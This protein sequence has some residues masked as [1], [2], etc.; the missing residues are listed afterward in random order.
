MQQAT[1]EYSADHYVQRLDLGD[2]PFNVDFHN[3]YFYAHGMR[4]QILDQVLHFGRFSDQAVLLLGSTGVGTSS[5][6]G[7][8]LDQLEPV[9]DFCSID[10]E[11]ISSPEQIL[12][13]LAEQMQLGSG[14]SA[15]SLLA[16]LRQQQGLGEVEPLLIAVD[17]AHFMG[18]EG[19]GLLQYLY[20]HAEG[21]IHLLLVGEYQVEQ[22]VRLV[23]LAPDQYKVLEIEPLTAEETGEYLL[24]L[25]QSVGYGGEQPLNRDQLAVLVERT[26][27]NIAE[28]KR[29]A[30]T[31]LSSDSKAERR[32]VDL[33]LPI[34]HIAAI[35]VLVVV[36]LVSY[37]FQSS[38]ERKDVV[39]TS[40]ESTAVVNRQENTL[41]ADDSS[42]KPEPILLS[43]PSESNPESVTEVEVVAL[44][45]EADRD[46]KEA[47]L[48]IVDRADEVGASEQLAPEEKP[49][50]LQID[51]AEEAETVE[52]Q[53][54]QTQTVQEPIVTSP[55]ELTPEPE[56]KP[57][58]EEAEIAAVIE[59]PAPVSNPL[60]ARE[61]KLLGYPASGYMLQLL[62]TVEERRIQEFSRQHQGLLQII[63]FE[64]RYKDKPWFVAVV[65]P[66][67]D[68]N[69]AV[70]GIRDLPQ[71]LQRQKP[72]ARSLQSIHQDIRSVRNLE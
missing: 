56:T 6:L 47:E 37:V 62:G 67:S 60:P 16:S 42:E 49:T 53:V 61:Q 3:D 66:Y 48:E 12:E 26:G 2:D 17:Q 18:L 13:T 19:L 70:A 69:A 32:G 35:A 33:P 65:G 43:E 40:A 20:E 45:K 59:E 14:E 46:N 25:L 34:T 41:V 58:V 57:E 39:I 21:I 31:L 36:I 44:D 63:Y 9:M 68:R 38:D 1:A 50:P 28:I 22:L 27:G 11:E 52:Q 8:V 24:G 4:R 71:A 10:A 23:G 72:W 29:V 30:P 51:Q 54:V 7:V 15:A 64:T 55:V 5:I